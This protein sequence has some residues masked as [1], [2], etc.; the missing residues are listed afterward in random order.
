MLGVLQC[1]EYSGALDTLGRVLVEDGRAGLNLNR[2][3]TLVRQ[4]SF[5]LLAQDPPNFFG[6]DVAVHSPVIPR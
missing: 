3:Q 4:G 6:A 1:G 5:V 2:F